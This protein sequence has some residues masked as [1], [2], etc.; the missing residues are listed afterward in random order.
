MPIVAWAISLTRSLPISRPSA[1]ERKPASTSIA[2]RR[3][4]SGW[5][6]LAARTTQ[7]GTLT[8]RSH[9]SLVNNVLPVT[10]HQSLADRAPLFGLRLAHRASGGAL[11]RG[12]VDRKSTRLNSSH[13]KI[14]YAV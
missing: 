4:L 12:P 11:R 10:S 2:V 1:T 8:R 14:S 3:A 9:S 13:V 5:D 7:R 6:A